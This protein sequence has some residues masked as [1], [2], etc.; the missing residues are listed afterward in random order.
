MNVRG[1][2]WGTARGQETAWTMGRDW[3]T[4]RCMAGN[5]PLWTTPQRS[6]DPFGMRMRSEGGDRDRDRGGENS[7]ESCPSRWVKSDG[8]RCWAKGWFAVFA[9]LSLIST[10][11]RVVGAE[12]S[13]P[14]DAPKSAGTK[15]DN[16]AET[17]STALFGLTNLWTIHLT[18]S[19]QDWQKLGSRGGPR[20][21][22][23][24][25]GGND[26]A[27]G[28]MFDGIIRG[29]FGGEEAPAQSRP[30]VQSRPAQN[31]GAIQEGN[32]RYPWVVATVESGGE[33]YTNVG[34]RFKGVSSFV[35]APNGYKR[36]FKLDFNRGVAGRRFKGVEEFY[37]NNNVN[38]AT[39]MREALAYDL[40]RRAGIPAPR[41]AFAQVYLTLPGKLEKQH[42]GLYTLVEAVEGDFLKRHFGT[43]KGLLLKP[44]MMQGLAY[45]GEDWRNYVERY[46]PKGEVDPAVAQ[47]FMQ[48]T[49]FIMESNP[50]TFSK[51]LKNHLDPEMFLRFVALNSVLA[52][53]DSFIGNGHNY[54]LH[55]HPTTYQSTFVPWDVNEAFGMHPVSGSSRSQMQFSVVR[56]NADPNAL[57]ERCVSDRSLN[58]IYRAQLAMMLTNIFLPSRVAADIDRIAAVTKPVVFAETK[59][60][61]ADFERTV[62]KTIAPDQGDTSQPRQDRE[63]ARDNYRPWGFPD[64]VE[65]D[66][67]PLKDWVEGRHAHVRDQLEGKVRGT[68]PRPRLYN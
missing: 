56:P 12:T 54:F 60:A 9:V 8:L 51:D 20:D 63:F 23:Y 50:E 40:F 33:T 27:N 31:P 19:P 42:L 4:L 45:M 67:M 28:G 53:V 26:G 49:R 58:R 41:T 66:N 16:K 29:V 13:V 43:K 15:A 32:S 1:E 17:N 22:R 65:I 36:P 21:R 6:T 48:F 52:N 38:D 46:D 25:G 11:S 37:L 55:V 5:Q 34:V 10:D 47:R 39:Q 14:K 57:V 7:R 3:R 61:R 18:I 59:R 68:R 24:G 62:L 35:R 44:E 2:S 30:R 64:A